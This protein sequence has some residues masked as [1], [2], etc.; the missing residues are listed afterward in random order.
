MNCIKAKLEEIIK[1]ALLN[2]GY[3][4][5]NGVEVVRDLT[6]LIYQIFNQI[7]RWLWLNH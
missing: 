3:E 6:D 1:D 5:P 4:L 7:L 2:L